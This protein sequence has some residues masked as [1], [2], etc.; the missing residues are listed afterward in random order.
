MEKRYW[1]HSE[2]LS[3]FN[4]SGDHR[5]QFFST[6]HTSKPVR[7]VFAR[8]SE[9]TPSDDKCAIV[10]TP[11]AHGIVRVSAH[12]GTVKVVGV[13]FDPTVR[14][15]EVGISSAISESRAVLLLVKC[16]ASDKMLSMTLT[17][18]RSGS[19]TVGE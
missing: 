12:H 7:N 8:A 18:L 9:C 16:L 19:C 4:V 1:N 11:C 5:K 2:R 10:R 15:D 6:L 14:V 13:I 17:Q 3:G